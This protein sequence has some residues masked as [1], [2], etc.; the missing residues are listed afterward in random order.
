MRD[1]TVALIRR[2]I[3]GRYRGSM[4]G[5]LWSMLTPLLM[6]AVYTFVFGIVFRARWDAAG[7]AGAGEAAGASEASTVG[8]AIVLFAGLI[9][10]Q[11]FAEVINRSPTLVL[12]NTNYVKKV[13]FPLQILPVVAL[14]SA[15]FHATVSAVVLFGF[16]L[17]VRGGIPLTALLWPM[18]L[19]PFCLMILG[20][21]WFLAALGVYYRDI[22]QFLGTV[23][24]A[25]MFLSP[26]FFPL[27]ALP[28]WLRHWVA[29]N[30]ISLPVEQTRDVLIF[31][32]VPD[33][34]S[35][36][37]YAAVSLAIATLGYAWF[38]KTRKGFA[39]V[40]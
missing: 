10:F 24:T 16:M 6:L 28:P 34:L 17:I 4:L 1:L 14:G 37:V 30:P 7:T 25:L 3:A 13:V 32:R 39:D 5:I 9:V 26:I 40:M 12:A 18:V 22:G 2:E 8:F 21:A 20:L 31:G 23:V 11:L 36:A 33:L 38:Q 19:A 35:L 15:L 27:S 29:L